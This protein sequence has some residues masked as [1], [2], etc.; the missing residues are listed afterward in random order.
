MQEEGRWLIRHTAKDYKTGRSYGERPPMVLAESMYPEVQPLHVALSLS[1]PVP[2]HKCSLHMLYHE[3]LLGFMTEAICLLDVQHTAE[4]AMAD[5]SSS[6]AGGVVG[7]LACRAGT[8]A[9][10]RV[11]PGERHSAD[12]TV[13]PQAVH[14]HLLPPGERALRSPWPAA[15]S[16]CQNFGTISRAPGSASERSCTSQ[17]SVTWLRSMSTL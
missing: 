7:P 16:A 3:V 6:A 17:R 11:H 15:S 2:R 10:L 1:Q 4:H 5:V 8:H 9:L 13:G 12:N 14:L